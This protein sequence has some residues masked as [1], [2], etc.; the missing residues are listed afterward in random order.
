MLKVEDIHTYYGDSYVIQGISFFVKEGLVVAIL[1]RNGMGK[2]TLIHSVSGLTPVK[3][4]KIIFKDIEFKTFPIQYS[5]YGI[6][7]LFPSGDPFFP[8]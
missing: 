1:G 7:R 4:G 2:T 5:K 6:W 8:L 3:T